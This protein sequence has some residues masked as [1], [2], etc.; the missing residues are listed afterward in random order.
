MHLIV[1]DANKILKVIKTTHYSFSQ[2]AKS[3]LEDPAVM[4]WRSSSDLCAYQE[5]DPTP[6]EESF[7][8]AL[9]KRLGPINSYPREKYQDTEQKDFDLVKTYVDSLTKEKISTVQDLLNQMKS[10]DEVFYRVFYNSFKMYRLREKCFQLAQALKYLC[11][12]SH[13]DFDQNNYQQTLD[14]K[15]FD[16]SLQLSLQKVLESPFTLNQNQPEEWAIDARNLVG[17]YQMF[18]EATDYMVRF[19]K[20]LL[21]KDGFI[22]EK[23]GFGISW[24]E[25]G[26]MEVFLPLKQFRGSNHDKLKS[27]LN[28]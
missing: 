25:A 17:T 20:D 24:H 26:A 8:L 16:K 28:L 3:Y 22:F 21:Q 2:D 23:D 15:N 11:E 4:V 18:F 19:S 27:Y 6:F 12:N 9:I 1:S 5:G 7:H 10:D 13:F 14:L